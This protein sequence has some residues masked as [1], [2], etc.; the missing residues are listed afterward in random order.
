MTTEQLEA[1]VKRKD[2]ALIAIRDSITALMRNPARLESLDWIAG[3]C[4]SALKPPT[5]KV[6][7]ARATAAACGPTQ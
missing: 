6:R 4:R 7:I 1:E 5:R 2:E 3:V